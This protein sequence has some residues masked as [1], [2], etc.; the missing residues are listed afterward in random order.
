MLRR[1]NFPQENQADMTFVLRS[2]QRGRQPRRVSF[3]RGDLAA[4]QIF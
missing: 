3:F 4:T 1:P 2:V